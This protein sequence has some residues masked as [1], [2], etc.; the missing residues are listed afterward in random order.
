M[1]VIKSVQAWLEGFTGLEFKSFQEILTDFTEELPSSYAL[2][3]AG[4]S[5]VTEDIMGNR[6]Y[7]NSY[8]LYAREPAGNEVDRAEN[9]D[10]L[11]AL[12]DWIEEQDDKRNYPQLPDSRKVESITVS[13]IMMF[14]VDD[15]GS[16]VYQ[17]Q[18][19]LIYTK[20]SN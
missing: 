10:F 9:Y 20:R 5:K 13:N 4:N 8:I 14:G 7:Q 6:T 12:N 17:I 19:Q 18:M 3:P 2:A 11:E 16:A 1:N 15:N